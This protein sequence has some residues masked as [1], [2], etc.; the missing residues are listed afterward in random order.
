VFEDADLDAPPEVIAK[1]KELRAA[2]ERRAK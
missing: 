1:E 2:V